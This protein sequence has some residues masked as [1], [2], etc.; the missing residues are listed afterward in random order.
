MNITNEFGGLT[1]LTFEKFEKSL[2]QKIADNAKRKLKPKDRTID[3][4]AMT[5]TVNQYV[6]RDFLETTRAIRDVGQSSFVGD[7]TTDN[8]NDKVIDGKQLVKKRDAKRLAPTLPA[9]EHYAPYDVERTNPLWWVKCR[10]CFKYLSTD[11]AVNRH[12]DMGCYVIDY[13]TGR[14]ME[15]ATTKDTETGQTR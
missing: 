12:L 11:E 6:S 3:S 10:D 1:K 13:K 4:R 2:F 8:D 9:G 7:L 14:R 5:I 15:R